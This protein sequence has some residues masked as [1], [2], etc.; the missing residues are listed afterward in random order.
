MKSFSFSRNKQIFLGLFLLIVSLVTSTL[1]ANISL[2]SNHSIEFSQARYAVQ[3]CESWIEIGFDTAP[4]DGTGY[5]PING[6]YLD[7][8]DPA[9]CAGSTI[10]IDV[11]GGPSGVGNSSLPLFDD[12]TNSNT[13]ITIFNFAVDTNSRLVLLDSVGNPEYQDDG[14]T[15]LSS[16]S[17]MSFSIDSA[18][19]RISFSFT[20]PHPTYMNQVNAVTLQTGSLPLSSG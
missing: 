7:G 5:S 20:H 14:T 11:F 2:N 16:D 8:L 9:A 15:P 13:P 1:A 3:A 12:V 6:L 17:N 18:T 4:V 10:S 19:Q